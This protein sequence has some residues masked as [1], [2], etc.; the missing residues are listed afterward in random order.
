MRKQE[1]RKAGKN[2]TEKKEE[3]QG[4]ERKRDAT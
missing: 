4:A 2:K 3:V 1:R